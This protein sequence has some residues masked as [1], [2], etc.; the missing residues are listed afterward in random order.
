MTDKV[1]LDKLT[2][3]QLLDLRESIDERLEKMVDEEIANLQKRMDR[4]SQYKE[5]PKGRS[6]ATK[7]T[8]IPKPRRSKGRKAPI[9]FRDPETGNAW[10][11]RGLTPVWLREYEANGGQRSDLAVL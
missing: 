3:D 6:V 1:S 8:R 9:K 11:G 2:V 7:A 5:S 10:S 4:L